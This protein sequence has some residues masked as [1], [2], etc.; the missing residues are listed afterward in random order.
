MRHFLTLVLILF[1]LAALL[2]VVGELFQSSEAFTTDN[3]L[4]TTVVSDSNL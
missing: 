3:L 1:L 2:P 4:R